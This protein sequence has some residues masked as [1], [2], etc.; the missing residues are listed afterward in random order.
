MHLPGATLHNSWFSCSLSIQQACPRMHIVE[1]LARANVRVW[2]G[3]AQ[4]RQQRK[5][6]GSSLRARIRCIQRFPCAR[7]PAAHTCTFTFYTHSKALR[8]FAQCA[9]QREC[10]HRVVLE[11]V[12]P[13]LGP[14]PHEG[15]QRVGQGQDAA[16][17]PC[18]DRVVGR[19]RCAEVCALREDGFSQ[20]H[21][22]YAMLS[23]Q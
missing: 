7:S 17:G 9:R 14:E 13:Q 19:R 20:T 5:N 15:V 1:A 12:A 10:L 23:G 22:A 21:T 4:P 2:A 6:G 3:H 18:I 8:T 16:Q 11:Q